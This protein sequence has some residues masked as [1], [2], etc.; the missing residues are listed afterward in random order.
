MSRNGQS[1][2]TGLPADLG[3]VDHRYCPPG[4]MMTRDAVQAAMYRVVDEL[5]TGGAQLGIEGYTRMVVNTTVSRAFNR[6]RLQ[7]MNFDMRQ[8]L[9]SSHPNNRPACA[10][11]QG[12]HG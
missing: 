2:V 5:P 9:M 6:V 3:G 7:R 12:P 4:L 8:R 10:P 11:I 1:A